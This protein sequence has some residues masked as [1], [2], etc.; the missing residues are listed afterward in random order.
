[1]NRFERWFVRRTFRQEVRQGPDHDKRITGLYAMIHEACENEFTED[2]DLSLDS[3][4]REQFEAAQGRI[5]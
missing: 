3:F 2:N 5:K 1:M 4:L